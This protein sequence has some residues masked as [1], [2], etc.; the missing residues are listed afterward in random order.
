MDPDETEYVSPKDLKMEEGA[1]ELTGAI[2]IEVTMGTFLLCLDTH[3]TH[4]T[5]TH[6]QQLDKACELT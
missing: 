5:S 4:T 6:H 1:E 2:S 3:Y